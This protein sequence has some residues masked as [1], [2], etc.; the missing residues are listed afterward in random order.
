MIGRLTGRVEAV[1]E[2]RCLI[3]VGGVGYVV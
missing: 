3:D 2:G 1:E